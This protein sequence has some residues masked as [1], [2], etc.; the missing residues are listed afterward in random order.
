MHDRLSCHPDPDG[1]V[2]ITRSPTGEGDS[3]PPVVARV[4]D[5]TYARV[6]ANSP[7]LFGTLQWIRTLLAQ[8]VCHCQPGV[9][10]AVVG[11]TDALIADMDQGTMP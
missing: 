3:P 7:V 11:L 4:Y 1:T 10:E 2:V 6:M 9:W 8:E 5:P